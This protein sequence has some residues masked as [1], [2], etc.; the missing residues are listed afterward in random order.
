MVFPAPLPDDPL[1]YNEHNEAH[2]KPDFNSDDQP[3][4]FSQKVQEDAG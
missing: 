2:S 1:T 3:F 4:W